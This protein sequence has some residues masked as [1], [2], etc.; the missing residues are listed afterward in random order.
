[1]MIEPCFRRLL[2][3]PLNSVV[4]RMLASFGSR[5]LF[6]AAALVSPRTGLLCQLTR[7]QLLNGYLLVIRIRLEP[8]ER[9]V[10][11]QAG[12]PSTTQ[13]QLLWRAVHVP[14]TLILLLLH[15]PGWMDWDLCKTQNSSWLELH[16]PQPSSLPPQPSYVTALERRKVHLLRSRLRENK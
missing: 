9:N 11:G 2:I 5:E 4:K 7:R 16:I 10:P 13:K 14:K 15:I 6:W 3:G 1:M 8:P 12:E